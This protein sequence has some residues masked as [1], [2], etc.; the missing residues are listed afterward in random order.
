MAPAGGS[1]EELR[2]STLELFFD[3]VFVFTITQ[4]A[5]VLSHQ[6]NLVGLAKMALLLG[7]IWWMYGGYAWLTNTVPPN[8]TPVRVLLVLAMIA[9]LVL[10]LSVPRA[11]DEDGWVFAG[12]YLVIIAVHAGLFV[13]Q[14]GGFNRALAGNLVIPVLLLVAAA[15]PGPV[16]WACWVLVPVLLWG[17]PCYR[18]PRGS[19][20]GPRTSSNGTGLC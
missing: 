6:P 18:A 13:A 20:F 17:R 10:A 3:L 19:R 2:V 14:G 16:R 9:Y 5:A 11:F 12:A 15:V 4:L 7:V 1:D 8:R